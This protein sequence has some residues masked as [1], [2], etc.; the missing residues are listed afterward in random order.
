M[1]L[2]ELSIFH[3][4]ELSVRDVLDDFPSGHRLEAGMR[5]AK[6]SYNR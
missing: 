6:L 3:D 2:P 5:K 4:G 1:V